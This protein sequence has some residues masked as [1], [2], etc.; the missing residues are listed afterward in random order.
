MP[1]VGDILANKGGQIHSIPAGATV[2]DATRKMNQAKIGAL[3]VMQDGQVA[4]IFTERDVLRRVIAEERQPTDVLVSEVM[5]TKLVCVN[6][7]TDI[8]EA[9]GVMQARKIRHLPVCDVRG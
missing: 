8:D 2:L 9:S 4:G 5:T 1:T 6:P 7:E 3:V